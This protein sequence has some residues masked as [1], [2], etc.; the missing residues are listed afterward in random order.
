M[1]TLCHHRK[2]TSDEN[3]G[4]NW[5]VPVIPHFAK[6]EKPLSGA[7]VDLTSIPLRT[8][9]G[10]RR[11]T[12][13]REWLRAKLGHLLLGYLSLDLLSVIMM[14]DPYFIL[15]PDFANATADGAAAVAL[16]P[17][18][19]SLPSLVLFT[20][21]SLVCF[22][23]IFLAIENIFLCAGLFAHFVLRRLYG[24]RAELWHFP[25]VFGSFI[26]GVADRGM[27]GFWGA[28]WHQTFRTAFAAPGLWLTRKGYIDS[29]SPRGKAAIGLLA[30]AQSGFLHC[31]GSVSCVPPG[32]PW[33]PPTFFLLSWA[34]LIVQVAWTA[35]LRAMLGRESPMPSTLRRAGNVVFV[36]AWLNAVQF[37]L[38]DDF[39]R[40][41]VWLLEPVPASLF[42]GLG[43]GKPGDSWWRWDAFLLPGW[44]RGSRW[45]LSGI[46]M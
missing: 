31:L 27:A 45:W 42:R 9:Q 3:T 41:G 40:A 5:C 14:K 32:K 10:Y 12:T 21:R 43:L 8:R 22:A 7:L 46:S 38:A 26:Y 44:Y 28:W 19:A 6:P 30:F 23:A 36:F 4:W 33:Q 15:G 1:S 24:T 35:A 39:A 25:S 29:R 11:Y 17:Y 2:Q 13:S 34:G 37:L 20:Y 18:L 16:P